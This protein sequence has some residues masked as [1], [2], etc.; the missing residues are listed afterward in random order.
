MLFATIITVMIISIMITSPGPLLSWEGS[1]GA[2][3]EKE[4]DEAAVEAGARSDFGHSERRATQCTSNQ[5]LMAVCG[6]LGVYLRVVL[7]GST[8]EARYLEYDYHPTPRSRI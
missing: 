3:A 2:E 5:G 7:V 1:E 6:Y 4:D 8:V